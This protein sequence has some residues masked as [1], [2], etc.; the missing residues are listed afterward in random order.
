MMGQQPMMMNPNMGYG[1]PGQ[2]PYGMQQPGMAPPQLTAQGSVPQ[3]SFA[4]P[5]QNPENAVAPAPF[6]PP[7]PSAPVQSYPWQPG[8]HYT[9]GNP[10]SFN[11]LY[12]A[13]GLTVE[14]AEGQENVEIPV[15]HQEGVQFEQKKIN[16]D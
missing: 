14:K 4:I 12:Y 6:V 3:Q 15:Q 7:A 9:V 5:G 8:V 13:D 1:Q 2:Q 10:V 11:Q 16:M